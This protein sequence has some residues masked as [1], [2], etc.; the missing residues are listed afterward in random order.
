[1]TVEVEIEDPRWESLGLA[2]L[3]ETATKATLDHLG[4]AGEISILGCDDARIT[5]LNAEFREKPTA[6][7]VLS[8]PSAERAADTPGGAPHPPE[9]LELGDIAIAYDTCARE[10]HASGISLDHHTLHLLVHGTLHLLGYD[11]I[12]DADASLMERLELEI[13][14]TMGVADPY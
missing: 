14:A 12:S 7:N 11:H 1:M 6:T 9:D 2:E 3:A 8:W 4:L 10:A 5:T 13:L